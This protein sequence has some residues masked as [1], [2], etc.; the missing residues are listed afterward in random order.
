MA[1]TRY[2]QTGVLVGS[3][4]YMSPEQAQG[5]RDLDTR[6]DI[7]SLGATLY[8]MVTGQVPFGG[9]AA[10]EVLQKHL[11]EEARPP[12]EI[13]PELSDDI[14]R[15]IRVMMAKER[16]DRYQNPVELLRE[17]A[18]FVTDQMPEAVTRSLHG[19]SA[20]NPATPANLPGEHPKT[21]M[22]GQPVAW[23]KIMWMAVAGLGKAGVSRWRR[24]PIWLRIAVPATLLVGAVV[25]VVAVARA[26]AAQRDFDRHIKQAAELSDKGDQ[27]T[28][29]AELDKAK[30]I[31]PG[32]ASVLV[33]SGLANHRM[34]RNAIARVC[35]QKA[36]SAYLDSPA[37]P[38]VHRFLGDVLRDEGD[39]QGAVSHY[40]AAIEVEPEMPQLWRV[41]MGRAIAYRRMAGRDGSAEDQARLRRRALSDYTEAISR[42]P[43]NAYLYLLRGYT[44]I[45]MGLRQSAEADIAKAIRL[46]PSVGN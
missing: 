44:Y 16:E 36:L 37:A 3:V 26:S 23:G 5:V 17:L 11:L 29:L 25:V 43:G 1:A 21:A 19:L 24:L 22:P 27:E 45:D 42:E 7:Y 31:R 18:E 14:C 9:T 13:N 12:Q 28:A 34:G 10:L 6:S 46:D 32:D 30:Q 40:S 35:L 4:H 41:F 38:L 15:I 8:F 20:L 33:L 2:T 39:L